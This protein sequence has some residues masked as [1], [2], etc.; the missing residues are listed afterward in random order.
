MISTYVYRR[1]LVEGGNFGYSTAISMFNSVINLIL[2]ITANKVSRK[3]SG[4]GL[5]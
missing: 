5:W 1:T 2:L 4:S 3:V